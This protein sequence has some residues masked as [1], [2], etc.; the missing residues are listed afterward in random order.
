MRKPQPS[1]VDQI[2]SAYKV[3]S[4]DALYRPAAPSDGCGHITIPLNQLDLNQEA[5]K[6]ADQW[7]NEE[8]VCRFSIGCC[9]FS[10]RPATIFAIEATRNLCAGDEGNSTALKL[11]RLAVAELEAL[12]PKPDLEVWEAVSEQIQ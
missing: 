11:L 5:T 3:M 8:E 10:T 6:Y 9:N 7:W 2:V 1:T 12:E 4:R